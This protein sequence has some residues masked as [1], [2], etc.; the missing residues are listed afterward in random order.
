MENGNTDDSS[1][2]VMFT[3]PDKIGTDL[4][5]DFFEGTAVEQDIAK[6]PLGGISQRSTRIGYDLSRVPLAATLEE[7][8]AEN[9]QGLLQMLSQGLGMQGQAKMLMKENLGEAVTIAEAAQFCGRGIGP[10][11]VGTPFQ[12]AHQLA[13]MCDEGGDGCRRITPCLPGCLEEVVAT[14]V[15][16]LPQR[17]RFRT[18][19]EGTTRRDRLAQDSRT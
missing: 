5:P 17:G 3:N 18:D 16:M 6:L 12:V 19:Y 8:A 13:A 7:F 14:A 10:K 9:G 15:P 2:D 1:H 4:C 11:S